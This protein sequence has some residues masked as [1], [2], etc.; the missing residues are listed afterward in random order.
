MNKQKSKL[1]RMLLTF[2]ITSI[3]L[4]LSSCSCNS[5]FDKECA[6]EY[7]ESVS[8]PDCT[9]NGTKTFTCTKCSESYT[10]AVEPKGH[11]Y[12]ETVTEPTCGVGGYTSYKCTACEHSYTD[13]ITEALSHHFK[14]GECAHC[15]TAAPSETI[16]ANTDWY[17]EDIT[18]FVIKTKEE[19]AGLASL[20]NSGTN[21]ANKTIHIKQNIDLE[22][23]EWTPIGNSKYAF[24]G[25]FDGD[26]KTISGLK[27]SVS[28]S[29]SGLF[30]NVSGN[31]GNFNVE[32]ATLYSEDYFEYVGI[33]CG[34]SRTGI[35]NVSTDGYLDVR[36]CKYVGGVVGYAAAEISESAN[37]AVVI[38]GSYVGGIG[39]CVSP[40]SAV[41]V[42]LENF[43]AVTGGDYTGGIIGNVAANGV[44]LCD[45]IKN[46]A[47]V[48]GKA[49]TGG[50]FG[51]IKANSGSNI[52][53]SSSRGVITGEY[54]VGGLIG[55]AD[56]TSITDCSNS[57]TEI[58]ATSCLVSGT[59]FFAYLGGYVGYG[60]S[61][62]GCINNSNINYI[63]RGRY[64]GG[65]AGY[66]TDAVSNCE[67][68]GTISSGADYVGGIVGSLVSN[69]N[70]S[71]TSLKNTASISGTFRIGGIMGYAFST[72]TF[73]ISNIE[74]SGA[75]SGGDDLGGIA[76]CVNYGTNPGAV[77]ASDL[78]NTGDVIGTSHTVGGLFG[79]IGGNSSSAVKNSSS[80]AKIQG[81]YRVGGLIGSSVVALKDSTNEGSTITA[82]GY[83][84]E[85]EKT[86]AY[87]GGYIGTTGAAISGCINK[88]DITYESVGERVGGIAGYASGTISNCENHGNISSTSGQVGGIVG[89]SSAAIDVCSNTGNVTTTGG[90]AVGGIAG[91]GENAFTN[92]NNSGNITGGEWSTGGIAGALRSTVIAPCSNLHNSGS[93]TGENEVGGIFGIIVFRVNL[94]YH[95]GTQWYEEVRSS[96][97]NYD[98]EHRYAV[99]MNFGNFE[100]TGKIEGYEK[101]GGIIGYSE[102]EN[103]HTYKFN[104]SKHYDPC[105]DIH[106]LKLSAS[107]FKN[108]GEVYGTNTVGEIFGYFDSDAPSTLNSYTVLGRITKADEV[109]EGSYDGGTLWDITLSGRTVYTPP[110]EEPE[111]PENTEQETPENTNTENPPAT[112]G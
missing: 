45:T 81:T 63:S 41:F 110:V 54:Y 84:I 40:S 104:C 65:I 32:N 72:G 33:T 71:I 53:A 47:N 52:K 46:E 26:G 67:N 85:G 98:Y 93:V 82:T 1:W 61:V 15:K 42:G 14:N 51:Y 28:T 70:L 74:N 10:E 62:S 112:E 21:F 39:G 29:Y 13:N 79:Y 80:S 3:L 92:C 27:I 57:G 111:S 95:Q 20:V 35:K 99:A 59:D 94:N 100:N 88:S 73:L 12:T 106:N 69:A 5:P 60:A 36:E 30:G 55:R 66:L 31:V 18:V 48:S 102:L 103:T 78:S 75:I 44:V 91:Y 101:V 34:Y 49:Y 4:I 19:L 64:V 87:L 9:S 76:G 22:F 43:G 105:I 50:I 6:H 109:K 86:H 16:E 97:K 2:A 90:N 83:I 68:H 23:M 11:S 25:T 58:S 56:G 107:N 89:C 7:T 108:L 77:T 17:S 38:G 37:T 24:N 96:D 8:Y